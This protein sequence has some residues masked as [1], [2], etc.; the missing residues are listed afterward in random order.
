MADAWNWKN[1]DGSNPGLLYESGNWGDLLKML[2]VHSVLDWK[3]RDG[4]IVNYLD[5]FAGEI[6]YPI[7]RKARHR[8]ALRPIDAFAF[9]QDEFLR[10]GYWPSAASG[11]RLT[12]GGRI[13]IWD[14]DPGRRERWREVPGVVV[15]DSE[16]G[17]SVLRDHP[18]DPDG[19]WLVDPYDFLAEWREYLPLVLARSLTATTLVYIYNRSAK[20][21]TAFKNYREFKNALE[22]N[23]GDRNKR[24]GRIEADVFLPRSHHEM[25]LLPSDDD[26]K[27]P[28]FPQLLAE[29][30]D[31]AFQLSDLY[32]RNAVCEA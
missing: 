24:L 7:S 5:P 20:S 9:I 13:E 16:S 29:L 25:L 26:A 17:W 1:K 21:E 30:E 6:Q 28:D 8:L 31:L 14:A 2:W 19:V 27:R 32:G 18:D 10:N 23:A 15:P 11:A 22:D 3:Q 4:T 12:A